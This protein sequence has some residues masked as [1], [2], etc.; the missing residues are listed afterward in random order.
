MFGSWT[1][2][3]WQRLAQ[4]VLIVVLMGLARAGFWGVIAAVFLVPLVVSFDWF[5]GLLWHKIQRKRTPDIR[6]TFRRSLRDRQ[7]GPSTLLLPRLHVE[8]LDNAE[9]SMAIDTC[10]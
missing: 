3:F 5:A 1:K 2:S 10:I 6:A 7:V 8:N 9:T 4:G